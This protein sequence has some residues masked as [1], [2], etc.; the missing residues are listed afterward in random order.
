M[1]LTLPVEP[2]VLAW[3]RETAGYT[4]EAVAE[5]LHIPR[6]RLA[7]WEA[8]EQKAGISHL[9]RLAT[10][11]KRPLTAFFLEKPP[12]ELPDPP[13]FRTISSQRA[14]LAPETRFAIRDARRW[15]NIAS[16]IVDEQGWFVNF[17]FPEADMAQSPEQTAIRVREWLGVS[18]EDQLK[19]KDARDA[20]N[21][22]R[23]AIEQRTVLV[24]VLPMPRED[25]LGFSLWEERNL[26]V[27]VVNRREVAEARSFT[28]LHEFAHLMLR[29]TGV[30]DQ[31][32]S[33]DRDRNVETYC[34]RV[35]GLTLIPKELLTQV[36]DTT[37]LRIRI[38]TVTDLI[39]A[40]RRRYRTSRHVAALRLEADGHVPSGTY[41]ELAEIWADE[42]W[43][44]PGGGGPVPIRYRVLSEKGLLYSTI[45]VGA[46]SEGTLSTLEASR[47]M[48]VKAAR[49][50]EIAK[51]LDF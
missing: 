5:K 26:P 8:G 13:D 9:R 16:E 42:D 34:N 43:R 32:E 33:E 40:A 3:A 41:V 19:W 21:G 7:A 47:L 31:S 35:A 45:L 48:E 2:V 36:V 22:W 37:K 10:I 20:F 50:E 18:D 38:P 24:F 6:E 17:T 14:G 4:V 30:C 15:Q 51:E 49:L 44:P 39:D 27:V 12:Q 28:L 46:W 11:Y 25:C 1:A 29:N 23:R